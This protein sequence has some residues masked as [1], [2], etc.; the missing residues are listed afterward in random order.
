MR[1]ATEPLPN[2]PA[3]LRRPSKGIISGELTPANLSVHINNARRD[4]RGGGA[5]ARPR[6]TGELSAGR[7]AVAAGRT[8]GRPA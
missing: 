2:Q 3:T 7:C 4:A 6:A 1:A 5:G 8:A